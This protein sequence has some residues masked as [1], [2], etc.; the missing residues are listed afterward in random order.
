VSGLG[1]WWHLWRKGDDGR[2]DPSGRFACGIVAWKGE[3][4]YAG[5]GKNVVPTLPYFGDAMDTQTKAFQ[6]AYGFED[7]GVIGPHTG[8][9]LAQHR[10]MDVGHEKKIPDDRLC[11]LISLESAN[12]PVAQGTVDQED[13]G[14]A[15]INRVFHPNVTLQEAWSPVF[16]VEWAAEYLLSAF[17]H[18]HDWDAAVVSYNQ[19]EGGAERW[20]VAGKPKYGA[21]YVDSNGVQRDHFTDCWKYLQLVLQAVC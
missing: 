1:G 8:R 19:G 2:A 20:L 16:A 5:F 7:D 4:I 17:G 18:L 15:Q 6:K 10:K 13:E 9:A 3:L 12:D 21:P 11:K 14:F